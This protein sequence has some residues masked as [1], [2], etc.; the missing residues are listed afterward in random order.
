MLIDET[1]LLPV[2]EVSKS[3]NLEFGITY[4][5]KASNLKFLL[6][7]GN[8]IENTPAIQGHLKEPAE[9][10]QRDQCSENSKKSI[11]KQLHLVRKE[12]RIH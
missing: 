2:R 8:F 5:V 3:L 1:K 11:S 7:S 12:R 10:K 9:A 6:T 4:Q